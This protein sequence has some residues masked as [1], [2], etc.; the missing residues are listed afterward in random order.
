MKVF[1]FF[2]ALFVFSFSWLL[3][4]QDP[5]AAPAA[6][7]P[8]IVASSSFLSGI[9]GWLN[10]HGGPVAAVLLLVGS[11]NALCSV[12]RDQLAKYD[13]VDLTKPIDPQYATLTLVN[14][15]CLWSGRI[16]DLVNANTQH[17]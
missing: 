11:F 17:K 3:L 8:A 6:V 1:K 13:G 10:A 14:K 15:I 16:L 5:A 7:A 12:I 9:W 2:A 4:A